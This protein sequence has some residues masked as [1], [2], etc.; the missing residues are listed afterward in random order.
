MA[1]FG[2]NQREELLIGN[3][4]ATET[5]VA[6][7]ISSAANEELGVYSKDGTAAAA[8]E[9]F[10]VLQKTDGPSGSNKNLNYEFSDGIDPRMV[11][12]VR[13]KAYEAE[14]QR[15]VT[16]T[17]FTG[18]P[19]T[20]ATYEVLI[21]LYDDGGA[22][23]TENFRIIGGYF[24]TDSST[25][26]TNANIIDGIIDSLENAQVLEGD[27]LFTF[28]NVGNN[29]MTITAQRQIGDPAK[30]I[31]DPIRFDVQVGVKSNG[32]DVNTGL[33]T[34]YN[35]LTATVTT[36]GSPG[37]GTGKY[38]SNLEWFTRGYKYEVYRQTGYPADFTQPAL[39]AD[40][41]GAYNIIHIDYY[42]KNSVVGVEEQ[43][44]TLTLAVEFTPGTIASNAATNSVLASLRT[45]IGSNATV[46]ADLATS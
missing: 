35:I 17:G 22:L 44:R 23:S 27:Q 7:F 12:S 32:A 31:A 9:K 28:A 24:V 13:L 30:D 41:N 4:V 21:R 42:T 34:N 37:A 38:V 40:Y 25:T 36:A 8:N 5:T 3:A 16:V 10:Y 18:T 29:S 39:Y 43:P 20:N 14:T 26:T 6:T 11:K 15:V 1:V 45:A 46:P 33:Y 2:P 19:Q